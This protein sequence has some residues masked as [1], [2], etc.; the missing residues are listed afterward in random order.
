[1]ETIYLKNKAF[2]LVILCAIQNV[3][4]LYDDD[5]FVTMNDDD[6]NEDVF[7]GDDSMIKS[8]DLVKQFQLLTDLT[9]ELAKMKIE[10]SKGG[11]S[12]FKKEIGNI[13]KSKK[14]LEKEAKLIQKK[15]PL[16][17]YKYSEEQ[18]QA[19]DF[20]KNSYP[21]PGLVAVF[22]I[23]ALLNFKEYYL[24]IF[25]NMFLNRP[26]DLNYQYSNIF[27]NNVTISLPDFDFFD[28][29][30]T[31]HKDINA[32]KLRFPVTIIEL[33]FDTVVDLGS[34]LRGS[35]FARQRVDDPVVVFQFYED[36]H[37]FST[38]KVRVYLEHLDLNQ[39]KP[40][41]KADIRYIPTT[42]FNAMLR[43]IRKK[44][45][46]KIQTYLD[47]SFIRD[48]SDIFNW[49]I[50]QYYPRNLNPL[51]GESRINIMLT[52]R[53]IIRNDLL[54]LYM[55]G[56]FFNINEIME[57]FFSPSQSPEAA[58]IPQ[59]LSI[60]NNFGVSI[61][62]TNLKKAIHC[63]LN[64]RVLNI[65]YPAYLKLPY[66]T[67]VRMNVMAGNLSITA[68]GIEIQNMIMNIYSENPETAKR[69][70]RDIDPYWVKNLSILLT[71]NNMN[72]LEGTVDVEII[73]FRFWDNG[74]GFLSQVARNLLNNFAQ[75]LFNSKLSGQYS[76]AKFA[77]EQGMALEK[78]DLH[79]HE[80]MLYLEGNIY[81]KI[82]EVPDLQ[83]FLLI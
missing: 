49:Y 9:K 66:M 59:E 79:Y 75:W 47:T 12:K 71:I 52:R 81:K 1:M 60:G 51:G 27:I 78:L 63:L 42:I 69:E 48:G 70:G 55:S 34:N 57:E 18:I 16:E 58:A 22:D 83:N 77:P 11:A 39:Y 41:L 32:I 80:N 46:R 31:M 67:D 28:V 82:E 45:F 4:P 38:P 30:L 17:Q 37:P 76:M 74:E 19:N 6:V 21:R 65:P 35:I 8:L 54:Y 68:E 24:P 14:T 53:P 73:S 2:L 72:L 7:S 13:F 62:Q 44:V 15:I 23:F 33:R 43:M 56:E 50:D 26:I 20:P 29:S 64:N 40:K 36:P 10:E 61:S 3:H 5:T 25:A